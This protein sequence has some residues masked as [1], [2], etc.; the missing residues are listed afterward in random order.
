MTYPQTLLRL[1]ELAGSASSLAAV[2]VVPASSPRQKLADLDDDG[3]ALLNQVIQFYHQSLLNSPEAQQWLVSRG[4]TH[5]ELV[6][7]FRLG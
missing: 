4:L 7:H 1:R 6:S 5:P 3:Q 2:P